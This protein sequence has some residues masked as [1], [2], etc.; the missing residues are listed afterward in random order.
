MAKTQSTEQERAQNLRDV[1]GVRPSA[2]VVFRITPR[3][4]M[5]AG[6]AARGEV[7]RVLGNDRRLRLVGDE[8]ADFLV[9]MAMLVKDPGERARLLVLSLP[10]AVAWRK[11]R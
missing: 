9:S 10:W 6:E 2:K 8:G 3:A 1:Q 11:M 7:L 5:E 4:D